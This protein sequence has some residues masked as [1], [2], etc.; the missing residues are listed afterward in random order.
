[1]PFILRGPFVL[2]NFVHMKN[3]YKQFHKRLPIPTVETDATLHLLNPTEHRAI[4]RLEWTAMF[5]SG[6]TGTLAV[7]LLYLPQYQFPQLFPSHDFD[8]P[9]VGKV[10]VP[11]VATIYGVVLVFL[12]IWALTLLHL[13]CIHHIAVA[14]GY[15]KNSS[16]NF[17]EKQAKILSI[18]TEEKDKT[19]LSY[20]INP[21][22]GLKM[23]QVWLMN[24]LIALKATLSNMIVKIIVRRFLGRYAVREV[25]DLL[26]IPIFAF[27]NIMATRTILREARVMI[28]GQNLIDAFEP[29]FRSISL[30][31]NHLSDSKT[32]IYDTLQFIA[33][34]KRDYH[35]NHAYL[36]AK[37]LKAFDI[38]IETQHL[39]PTNY[40]E[41]LAN[42][43]PIVK[44]FCQ[45]III[46]GLLLDGEISWRERQR[47]QKL[48]SE[49]ILEPSV[50]EIVALKNDFLEGRGIGHLVEK[51]G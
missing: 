51:L 19:L 27:W 48:H 49:G 35:A 9:I 43:D 36:T 31:I 38:P 8:L 14:T 20:G 47:I 29:N 23:S 10:A 28:M 26:G 32:L 45:F 6:L 3:L 25:L 24:S 5:A 42:A 41:R 21:F 22:Q 15:L 44:N 17:E 50:S 39:V 7:L 11:I 33:V 16:E 46:I 40:A 4:K 34:S 2:S 12:E 18:S 13:Y 1:M 37:V 30:K